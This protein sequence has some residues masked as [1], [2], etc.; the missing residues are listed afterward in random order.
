MDKLTELAI[1]YKTDK[2]GKHTYTPHYFDMFRNRRESV[3]KVL[4]IGVGEGA[5]LRMWRDFFP[6]AIIYGADNQANRVFI[7]PPIQVF[8][9]DQSSDKD[10]ISLVEKTGT[11][12]DLVMDDGSHKQEDQVFTCLTLMP[13]LKKDVTYVIEDVANPSIIN[14]LVEKYAT[15]T[16]ECGKRYDDLLV[17]VKNK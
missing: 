4:E 13:L 2:W 5:G 6:N 16:I 12:I 9:C 7:D 8:R 10:L 14:F 11:D 15:N 1:K 17:V 3:K